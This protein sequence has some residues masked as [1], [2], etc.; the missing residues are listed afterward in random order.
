MRAVG[1]LVA[2]MLG[3]AW[4]SMLA[5]GVLRSVGVLGWTLSFGEAFALLVL[6]VLPAVSLIGF[7]AAA[8]RATKEADRRG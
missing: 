4:T 6:V 2:L 1:F 3:Y 7:V 8:V 5:V